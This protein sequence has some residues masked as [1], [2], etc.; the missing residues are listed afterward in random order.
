MTI[1]A[2]GDLR[3]DE[4]SGFRTF[5]VDSRQDRP[6]LPAAG[7]PFCPGGL[8]APEDYDVRWFRNRWP[9]MPDGRCE[10]VLYTPQHDATFW[11]LGTEGAR[12][13]VDL[14]AERTAALGER[15]DV[16]YVLVFENRGAAVGATISHPH[17]QIYAFDFV[18]EL[19][20]RELLR[21]TRLGEPG[22]RLVA[23]S[24]GWRAWVPEA[25]VF[26]FALRLAPAERVPDLPSLDAG[27]RDGLAELLVDVLRRFDRLFDGE[28][29][30]MLWIHQRPFDGGDWPDARLHLE[31]VTPW[32]AP[33][34]MRYVA[35]GELGSG[36]Y[37]NPVSPDSAAQSLRDAV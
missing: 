12:K 9:A 16:D 5:M 7:C 2:R 21:G 17:G 4:L 37:F 27:G 19:P 11:S 10:V 6:N 26:P 18:P 3:T 30:Y 35:A 20:R 15:D 23:E 28:T 13:V 36:V 14:W 31:I 33:G 32:R 34:V 25:P 8:E 1:S 24:P 22:D 29:P